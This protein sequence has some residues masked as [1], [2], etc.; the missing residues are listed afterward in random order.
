MNETE[1]EAEDALIPSVFLLLPL[2]DLGIWECDSGP[3]CL[4]PHPDC[5]SVLRRRLPEDGSEA[6]ELKCA[7][8]AWGGLGGGGG[9]GGGGGF[10]WRPCHSVKT[11]RSRLGP[12]VPG[13]LVEEEEG[14]AP[15]EGR[16]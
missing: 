10:I 15:G 1:A 2:S 12:S 7:S 13:A 14:E 8:N 9:G 16:A 3:A 4:S 6:S 5:L 11:G